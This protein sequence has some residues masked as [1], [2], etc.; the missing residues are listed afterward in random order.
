M[1]ARFKILPDRMPPIP[2]ETVPLGGV[3]DALTR[4]EA[5]SIRG[6]VLIANE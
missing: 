6:R 5:G 1:E 3:N 2:T 4:L